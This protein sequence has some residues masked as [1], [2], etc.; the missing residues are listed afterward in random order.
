MRIK[1]LVAA[2]LAAIS[3]AAVL[4]QAVQAQQITS[5]IVGTVTDA[6]GKPIPGAKVTVTDTRT[7]VAR[8]LSTGVAGTFSAQNLVVGGPYTVKVSA[9]GYE[10]QTV[11]GININT[12]GS[13][14]TS[15]KLTT[16]GGAI[17]VTAARA[18]VTQLAI[19]PGSAFNIGQISTAPSFNRDI[20]DVIRIDPRVSLSRDSSSGQNRI[21][22]LGG[23]DRSNAF[24]VDGISQA[25]AFGLNGNGFASRSSTPLPYSAVRE[26][27]VEFAPYDVE[28]GQFTG[29]AINVIT[30]SGGNQLHGS[31]FFEYSDS[32]LRG[33]KVADRIAGPVQPQKNWG[34]SL[35]GPIIPDRLFFFGA[36]SH[37]ETGYSFDYGPLGSGAP[38]ELPGVTLDQFNQVSQILKD[39]YGIDTGGLVT[40]LPFH[41]DRYFARID[42]QITD[43]QRLELTY[44]HL[45]ESTMKKGG[46]YT[47]SGPTITGSDNFYNSGTRSDYY[48]ARLYSDWTDNFSTEIRYA[49]SKVHDI[50][51]PVGGGEAQSGNGIPR[52]DVGTVDSNNNYGTIEAGPDQYRSANAL[53]TTIDNATFIGKLNAGDHNIKFG[54]GFNRVHIYNLFIINANGT[55][56]FNTI[57]DL[58]NGILA[59][60]TR[61]N[62]YA[63]TIHY[64]SAAGAF[65]GF[66][67]TGNPNDAAADFNRTIYSLF[68]QDDW[69]ITDRL[70]GTFGMRVDFYRGGHPALNPNFVGRYGYPNTTGFSDL[71]PVWMPRVAFTYDLGDFGPFMASKL[72]AGGGV[73]SGGDPLVWFG[74]AF[75]NNGI[76]FANGSINDPQCSALTQPYNVL[77]G[78]QFTG[79]PDCVK[80]AGSDR[81]AQALGNTQ[82]ISP[83]IKM[84]SVLRLNLG[85]ETGLDLADSG[86]FS[87]WNMRADLIFSHFMNP[88]GIVDLSQVVNRSQGLN[89]YMVDGRPI[90]API[91]PGKAGCNAVYRGSD[92]A[93]QYTDVNPECFTLNSYPNTRDDELMLTNL[94]SYNSTTLSFFLAKNFNRGIFTKGGSVNFT[95]GYAYNDGHDRATFTSSTASGLYDNTAAFDRQDLRVGRAIYSNTH[96]FTL[97][98]EFTEEFFQ[99]YKSRLGMTFVAHSGRPFGFVFSGHSPFSAYNSSNN[100]ASLYIPSG[101]TDPNI[102]PLSNPD[103]VKAL[104]DFTQSLPCASRY[105]GQTIARNTCNADWYF[106]MDLTI[107]Q[108]IPGPGSLFGKHD[109]L[110][111]YATMDNFLNFLNKDWNVLRQRTYT[112]MQTLG[113]STGVDSQGRYILS[114]ATSEAQIRSTYNNGDFL[115]IGG[116]VWRLKVGISY[117][118]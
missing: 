53:E 25:D 74:N 71:P 97:R 14:S 46:F 94:G 56:V 12:Q 44:Q 111:L 23:N 62:S 8:T 98:T 47:G 101:T 55:L 113:V 116:S 63:S 45:D 89:G 2:S 10:G 91:D 81:A 93:P 114:G 64:G 28:Y 20:R 1:F 70:E 110:K 54:A 78:G 32:N 29:C 77:Q 85:F 68:A 15:F 36:Y 58:Q 83:D 88:F 66:T 49:H 92:P 59:D 107:S 27:S 57:S 13:T 34:A 43:S 51:D 18:N 65:G 103:T 100:N 102:S 35:G 69:Q 16:G 3:T 73:F 104:Y 4:P 37:Q 115:S 84:A 96:N 30:K 75:Q 90:Y 109:K 86:F 26:V 19:G 48:S 7:A 50:Q 67:A 6:S 61:L 95:F 5:G 24:T 99:D 17:V 76:A 79:V 38:N 9:Q 108:E 21:S 60:G 80:Q 39:K 82:S 22:C 40:N 117:A 106:D 31:A 41:N 87:G 11:S 72:R 52:I 118:F 42:A 105:A 112:G 33:T